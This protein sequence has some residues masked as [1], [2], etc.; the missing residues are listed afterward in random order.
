MCKRLFVIHEHNAERA[1]LHWDIRFET[2]ELRLRSFVIPKHRF[3]ED[4]EQLLCIKV[5]DHAW[6]WGLFEGMILEG[7]GKG[8]VKIH[9]KGKINVPVFEPERIVF[10]YIDE[11]KYEIRYVPNLGYDKYFI[12]KVK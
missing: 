6:T 7:Y 10:E 3:P 9:F 4:D 5:H 8:V 11:N 12:K 1:G 2:L